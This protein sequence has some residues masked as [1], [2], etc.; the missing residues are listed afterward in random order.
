MCDNVPIYQYIQSQ[1]KRV[2]YVADM[3]HCDINATHCSKY[4]YKYISDN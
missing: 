4:N 1:L 2:L 3:Q